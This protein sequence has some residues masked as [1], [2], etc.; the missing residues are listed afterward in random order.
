[1]TAHFL[2]R[3]AAIYAP[4]VIDRR[5]ATSSRLLYRC[6]YTESNVGELLQLFVTCEQGAIDVVVDDCH[7]TAEVAEKVAVLCIVKSIGLQP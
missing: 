4:G 1:M 6:D 3:H 2:D 5:R 7:Y